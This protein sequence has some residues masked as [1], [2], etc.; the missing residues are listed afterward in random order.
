MKKF[1]FTLASVHSVREMTREKAERELAAAQSKLQEAS[2]RVE[3]SERLREEATC[4]YASKLFSGDIDPFEAALYSDHLVALGR[5]EAEA[6]ALLGEAKR[7]REYARQVLLDASRGEEATA[8]LRERQRE[9]HAA[10]AAKEEQ[11]L[12]DEMA[13]MSLARRVNG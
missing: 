7:A 12:L 2:A 6:Q 10:E 5:R 13:T 4:E 11:L 8:R 3:E 1:K 9:R